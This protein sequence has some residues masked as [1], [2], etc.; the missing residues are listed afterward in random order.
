MEYYGSGDHNVLPLALHHIYSNRNSL[1][2]PGMTLVIS[3]HGKLSGTRTPS[4]EGKKYYYSIDDEKMPTGDVMAES[5]NLTWAIFP[6]FGSLEVGHLPFGFHVVRRTSTEQGT[7]RFPTQDSPVRGTSS[8]RSYA[9][10]PE[11]TSVRFSVRRNELGQVDV[12]TFVERMMSPIWARENNACFEA[13]GQ[14]WH[15]KATF[16]HDRSQTLAQ[17]CSFVEDRNRHGAY[18][19]FDT[20]FVNHNLLEQL[21]LG[22]SPKMSIKAAYNVIDYMG[23]RIIGHG[24]ISKEVAYVTSHTHG[25]RFITGP[26]TITCTDDEFTVRRY[27]S[28]VS[29]PTNAGM[30]EPYGFRESVTMSA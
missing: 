23:V 21:T 12:E 29:P 28:V 24:R 7:M 25:P 13:L 17:L 4:S 10:M 22:G 5:Q 8:A 6:P 1:L 26:T 27:C 2:R 20:M 15:S 19:R 30:A 3:P 18:M 16:K 9:H 14:L 11:M